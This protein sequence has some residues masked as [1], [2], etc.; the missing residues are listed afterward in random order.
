MSSKN[1]NKVVFRDSFK[2]YNKEDV[3]G[4]IESFNRRYSELS[5]ETDKKIKEASQQLEAALAEL[6][7]A[8]ER[9]NALEA[10]NKKLFDD[11]AMAESVIDGLRE[12]V[13]SLKE[14][15]AELEE[16]N[17]QIS[18]SEEEDRELDAKVGSIIVHANEK[19]QS[20]ISDAEAEAKAIRLKAFRDTEMI[21]IEAANSVELMMGKASD[22]LKNIAGEC[23]QVYYTRLEEAEKDIRE[24]TEKADVCFNNIKIKFDLV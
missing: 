13:D 2:G 8:K 12:T 9:A 11:K 7:E 10:E 16:K 14:R 15:N 18:A 22:I 3:N 17:A 1:E 23:T 4:Y 21:K 6:D 19:A 24:L 20:I 5:D